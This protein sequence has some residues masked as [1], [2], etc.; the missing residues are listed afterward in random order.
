MRKKIILTVVAF[1]AAFT[2]AFIATPAQADAQAPGCT[3]AG[4]CLHDTPTVNP[5]FFASGGVTRNTC[6]PDP[7]DGIAS[8]VTEN[9]GVQW[10][11][12]R[13]NACDGSHIVVHA[14]VNL[15]LRFIS[16]WDNAVNAVMRTALTN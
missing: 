5:F 7:Q 12:F 3:L 16:G 6:I 4:F 8:F 10:W 2:G 13:T 1:L 11:L 9:T 14:N 15:D